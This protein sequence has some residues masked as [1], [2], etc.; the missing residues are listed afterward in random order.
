[1]RNIIL[2]IFLLIELLWSQNSAYK[3]F[4]SYMSIAGGRILNIH[5][6]QEQ[7]GSYFESDG[8][9]Y[10]FSDI[11]YAFD[12]KDQRITYNNDMITTINKTTKQIIYDM[13]I[14]NDISVLDILSGKEDGLEIGEVILEKNG[15]KIPFLLSEWDIKGTL[16]IAPK[17]G[18]PKKIM[19]ESYNDMQIIIKIN[20][21]ELGH[22]KQ[23]PYID[24]SE[25]E[26]IDLRE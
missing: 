3:N 8:L 17:T 21:S 25:Y 7:S 24:I 13:N 4:Q 11:H 6:Y 9:L 14:E 15:Y 10:Y 26:K 23:I 16:W 22:K 5:F 12:M 1:M 18:E 20:S 19:L 2:I